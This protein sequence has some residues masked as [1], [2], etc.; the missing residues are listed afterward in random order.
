M[1]LQGRYRVQELLGRGGAAAVYRAADEVLD[2]DVAVK[3][4]DANALDETDTA[5]QLY[6][7][8]VLARLSHHG[9]VTLLDAGLGSSDNDPPHVFLVMELVEGADLTKRL[10]GGALPVVETANIG[11][12]IAEALEYI[13]HRGIVH[14]DVKPA[15]ILLVRYGDDDTRPRAKLTDFGIAQLSDLGAGVDVGDLPRS[16]AGTAAYISPEQANG[17]LVGPASDVY[18]LGLVLLEC[19]TGE[20]A[21]PGDPVQTL[22]AR[23]VS[24]PAIPETVGVQWREL[25]CAM[26]ARKP[27]D[28]PLLREV[29][30]KLRRIA[31]DQLERSSLQP[32][33]IPENEAERMEAVRRFEILDTPPDGAF[34]RISSLAARLLKAPIA[35][36]SIVDHDRIW[37]KSHHGVEVEQIG[38]EPGLCAS[39]ILHG[40]PWVVGDARQDPRTLANPLVA[41]EFGLQ[42]YAGVPLRTT[43]GF[44]LGTL[45]VLDFEPRSVS[46]EDIANLED[47]AGMVMSQLELRLE[48]R[49]ALQATGA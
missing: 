34:D 5:R 27:E 17:D 24:D 22:V 44:R 29:I 45:C 46:D 42:F 20:V 2:R 39:A 30:L 1:L 33:L 25:I 19:L 35:I 36:V 38:R 8:K 49:R 15:N 32:S 28:R 21:F 11:Y 48:S 23:F 26:T 40:E 9:L 43:D 7:V 10:V 18:S 37:F 16:T 41:G 47:L 14:R 13:H 4:F 12:D 3:I 31:F 6:E